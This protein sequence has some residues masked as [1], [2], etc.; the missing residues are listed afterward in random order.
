MLSWKRCISLVIFFGQPSLKSTDQRASLFTVSKAFVRS[1]NTL[2][3]S[4]CCSMYFSW[5]C[6][7]E[8]TMSIVLRPG[9]DPHCASGRLSSEMSEVSLFRSIRT[10]IFPAMDRKVVPLWLPQSAL[11]PF[12]FYSVTMVASRRSAGMS[13]SSHMEQRTLWDTWKAVYPRALKSS[14]EVHPFLV[15]C[16]SSSALLQS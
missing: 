10:R 8:K 1:K 7:T 11:D 9:R 16:H 6:C 13:S 5:I 2:Y 3:R 14:A 4:I 15:L 12:F